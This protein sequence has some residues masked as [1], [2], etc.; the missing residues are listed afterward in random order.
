MRL[1]ASASRDRLLHIFDVD[2]DFGLVQ[3]LDDHS[4]AVTSLHFVQESGAVAG[5]QQGSRPGQDE[6]LHLISCGADK[7]L[8]F[9][10]AHQVRLD[11]GRNSLVNVVIK[12]I[13]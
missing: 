9:R 1:L 4:A 6:Q 5:G 8:L 12:V 2:Q 7:S 11:M 13:L 10:T 3:T